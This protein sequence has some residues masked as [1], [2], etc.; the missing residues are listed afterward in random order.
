MIT[1]IIIDYLLEEILQRISINRAKT[2]YYTLLGV[3]LSGL[4]YSFYL[5]APLSYGMSGPPANEINS[6]MYKMK[7]LDSWEF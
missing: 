3:V 7:W 4:W 1:A 6:T 5:F 2:I